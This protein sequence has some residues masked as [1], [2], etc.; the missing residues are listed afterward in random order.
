[1]S[2][3]PPDYNRLAEKGVLSNSN[4]RFEGLMKQDRPKPSVEGYLKEMMEAKNEEPM[5]FN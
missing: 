2:Q 4:N 1:M 3:N 5:M